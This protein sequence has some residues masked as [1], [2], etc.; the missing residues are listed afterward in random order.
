M[1]ERHCLNCKTPIYECMGCVLSR[2][3]CDAMNGIIAWAEIRE[4]CSA[5]AWKM[6]DTLATDP[7]L[8]SDGYK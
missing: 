5:C 8:R 1:I 2:D 6:R 3:W 7:L 4:L